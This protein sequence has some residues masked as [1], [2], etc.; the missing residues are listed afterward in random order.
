MKSSLGWLY[1][2]GLELAA[3]GYRKSYHLISAWT[4]FCVLMKM[5]S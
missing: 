2:F 4:D 1:A 5:G 3:I